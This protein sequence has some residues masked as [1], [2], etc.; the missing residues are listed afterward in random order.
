MCASVFRKRP[1]V[2]SAGM[3]LPDRKKPAWLP[4]IGS[5]KFP[6]KQPSWFR[7]PPR[8]KIQVFSSK[9][10]NPSPRRIT[11]CR[12]LR[13]RI[14]G[15]FPPPDDMKFPRALRSCP[16]ARFAFVFL[17]LPAVLRAQS[18][19]PAQIPSFL[20]W[21]PMQ[22]VTAGQTIELDMHRFYFAGGSDLGLALPGP[23]TGQYSAAFDDQTFALQVALD[24]K[25]SGLI[26]IPLRFFSHPPEGPALGRKETGVASM[27]AGGAAEKPVLEGVLLI[28]VR[29]ADGNH[30]VYRP[31]GRKVGKVCVAGQFNGWNTTSHELK[32]APDGSFELFVPMSP[33]AQQYKFVVDGEWT[34][35]PE[36]PEQADDGSGG[37]NSVARVAATDRGKPPVVFARSAESGKVVFRAVRGGSG[38]VQASTVLQLP[39][40][41]SRPVPHEISGEDVVV[42]AAG[43]PPGSWVRAVVSDAKG[44]VSNAARAPVQ[45]P[46]EFQWQDGIIYYAF[47][48]RFANGDQSNDRP[49]NDERV[50]PQANYQ[51]GDFQ[52]IRRKIDE[53]YFS[54]LGVNVLWLA[55][56]NRN[57]DGAWQE[58]LPPYRFY[59]GYHGYWPV[60][61]TEAEPRF[62]GDAALEEMISAAHGGDIYVIADLVLKHVHADHPLRKERPELFGA[63]E[64]PD[65]SK[66]LR[67]WDDHQFTTWFE[68]WLPAFDFDRPEAVKFLIGNAVDFAVRYKLDGYR[69]DAVKHIKPS[70]W[71]RYRTAMRTA[72]DPGRKVPLY[73]VGETFMD[74]EGIMRFVGPNM[75][76][77][78][79]DFP[80]YDTIID[81]FAKRKSGFEELEKSL[82]SSESV[83]GKETLMSPLLGNHD[84]A[85]FMAY[86]DGDLPDP[87]ESDEEE[88]GWKNPPKVDDP[89]AYE[90][91]KLGLTFV[92]GIDGVPMIYYGDEIGMSGAGDPDNRRMMR[93]GDGVTAEENSVRSH[94]SKVAKARREH[95][96]LR[97]GSRRPLVADGD[98][99][100]FVRAHLGDSALLAWNRGDNVTEYK[101][102]VA[103]E[104]AD[105]TYA[106]VLSGREIEVK[107]GETAFKLEPMKSALFVAKK[108]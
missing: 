3:R 38:I 78:Q 30:F 97:Y 74:R 107:N 14:D 85:R 103:P 83:Y 16:L 1:C 63:L 5:A 4:K 8:W 104:M 53:G 49:V 52:G 51:G 24:K 77:G 76:D 13:P 102:D 108:D 26:E 57:P 89:A 105:G 9:S 18:A 70:F 44:N 95:P 73:S 54:D 7:R 23:V 28:G 100:A 90:R 36:N 99:Y 50:P 6:G 72:V 84:K 69:L 29:P 87:S 46:A 88:V 47:T 93:W 31:K 62:G 82:S 58:Y 12:L 37:R 75:L 79:F 64:L 45:T 91:L 10:F 71:W 15:R 22:P 20:G 94:F 55:P 48:D 35:D 43:A 65:G 59:T 81:V 32:P 19:A 80:L 67:R 98:R 25:A 56:L 41:N 39:D 33:G 21:I 40:G 68:E 2:S 27:A 61:H 11:N 86:A 60:S 42:D 92:L 106:D 96:S 34:L 66:N 17:V 101:F